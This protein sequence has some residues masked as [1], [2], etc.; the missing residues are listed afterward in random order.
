MLGNEK[1]IEGLFL[2]YILM[3]RKSPS[4]VFDSFFFFFRSGHLVL[5]GGSW[6]FNGRKIDRFPSFTSFLY[7]RGE[8]LNPRDAP[9]QF[10]VQIPPQIASF[11]DSKFKAT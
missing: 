10:W 5:T 4:L 6:F 9:L 11:R 7:R 2:Q 1:R 3:I 8:P